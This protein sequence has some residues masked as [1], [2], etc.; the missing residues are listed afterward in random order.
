MII[1]QLQWEESACA[2]CGS[3]DDELIFKGP[4]RLHGLPGTFRLVRC[5][6]CGIFRQNPRL[7]WDSLSKYYPQDYVSYDYDAGG[8]PNSIRAKIKNR[9]NRKR[10]LAIEHFQPGG[11]LLE[12]GCGTGAFSRELLNSGHWDV[13]GIEPNGKAATHARRTLGIPVHQG[14][15]ADAAL[16]PEFFDAIVL[17]C[18]VEH[19]AQP[20]QD[21]RRA[22]TLLKRGGWLFFSVPNCESLGGKIFGRFWSGWDLPRHLY[23]FPESILHEILESVGFHNISTRCISTSYDALGHSLDFWS[24]D[25]ADKYPKLR[26]YLMQFYRSWIVRS[27][28]FIPLAILERFNLTTNITCFAQKS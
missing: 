22:H 9:G 27:G 1:N 23:V 15:F 17:W 21:L 3:T 25:W 18:V 11:R 6:Q 8:C 26:H 16:E 12:V 5:R 19:L 13:V 14:A 28:L 4:D 7:K 20:I 10:R 2:W 24:Q